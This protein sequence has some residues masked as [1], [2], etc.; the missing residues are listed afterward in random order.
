LRGCPT[1]HGRFAGAHHASTRPG[2]IVSHR[3]PLAAVRGYEVFA[4]KL[5]D[6]RKVVL[7]PC[8]ARGT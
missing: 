2:A 3:L 7:T 6:C 8:A 1:A 5:D 4:K